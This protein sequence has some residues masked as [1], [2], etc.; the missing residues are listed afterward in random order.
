M[1]CY[2]H[3]HFSFGLSFYTLQFGKDVSQWCGVRVTLIS[4]F[5]S[6][7]VISLIIKSLD[8]F[9]YFFSILVFSFISFSS[10]VYLPSS[11][12]SFLIP[13][14]PS[15]L[16]RETIKQHFSFK[17]FCTRYSSA[18]FTLYRPSI[19]SPLYLLVEI[20]DFHFYDYDFCLHS[21]ICRG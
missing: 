2:Y 18:Y 3:F 15:S 8:I 20:H 5:I 1:A 17:L 16:D 6:T 7:F 11:F 12:A 4:I 10:S 13:S 21:C 9:H 19:S 14:Y